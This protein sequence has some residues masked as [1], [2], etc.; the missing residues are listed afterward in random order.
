MFEKEDCMLFS[1]PHISMEF[2]KNM[3][4]MKLRKSIAISEECGDISAIESTINDRKCL[5]MTA[6][7]PRIC[8]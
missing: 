3:L 2:D 6:N 7:V 8:P 5:L 1:T 4:R